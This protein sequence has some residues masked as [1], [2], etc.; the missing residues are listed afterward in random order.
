MK[1]LLTCDLY[2]EVDNDCTVNVTFY[3]IGY[4][5]IVNIYS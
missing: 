3:Y 4:V 5:D 2:N 1:S